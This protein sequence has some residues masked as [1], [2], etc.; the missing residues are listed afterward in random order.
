LRSRMS[1][2]EP[3]PL[4]GGGLHERQIVAGQLGML[5]C[6]PLTHAPRELECVDRCDPL[7]GTAVSE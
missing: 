3:E 1:R 2:G 5:E 6:E 7:V 4:P